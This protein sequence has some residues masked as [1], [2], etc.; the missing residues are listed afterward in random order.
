MF[1]VGEESTGFLI[2]SVEASDATLK[3]LPH[4][5]ER[6]SAVVG[7]KELLN[8]LIRM[9]EHEKIIFH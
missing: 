9:H 1:D 5:G 6:L 7:R 4:P 3:L 8:E 2:W